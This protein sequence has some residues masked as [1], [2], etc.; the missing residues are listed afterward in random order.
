MLR[1]S[2]ITL[3]LVFSVSVHAEGFDYDYVSIGYGNVDFDGIGGDG[4]GIVLNAAF[5][6]TDSVHLFA[7]FDDADVNSAVDI[8][9]W[10]AG[11]GYNTSMSDTLDLF[12]RLSYESLDIGN[13]DD[14]GYGASVGGRLKAGNQIEVKAAINYVD[15]GD[16][17]ND[18]GLELGVLYDFTTNW[19]AGLTTEWS[20][21]VTTYS[22]GARYYF[23][24]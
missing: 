6:L 22:I 16:F 13:F 12:G 3:L 15:Y 9:R 23:G 1:S 18:T 20:D 14:T 24:K 2:L 19:T 17:G 5:G 7:G 8:T 11:V 21:D 4:D 10:N